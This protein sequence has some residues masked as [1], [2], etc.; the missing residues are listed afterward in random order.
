[1]TE[2]RGGWGENSHPQIPTSIIIKDLIA[3]I[4]DMPLTLEQTEQLYEAIKGRRDAARG[5]QQFER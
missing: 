3:I 2:R 1:M 4:K 5:G